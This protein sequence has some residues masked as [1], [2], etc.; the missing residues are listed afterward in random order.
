MRARLAL[1]TVALLVGGCSWPGGEPAVQRHCPNDDVPTL[2]SEARVPADA[3]QMGVRLTHL[4]SDCALDMASR[5]T[6]DATPAGIAD[7]V[8]RMGMDRGREHG[9]VGS[10]GYGI[11]DRIPTPTFGSLVRDLTIDSTTTA[12]T[13]SGV[14]QLF[15]T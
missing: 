11:Q 13:V 6:V 14:L 2:L 5:F 1:A 10:P 4:S 3:A 12:G 7:L 15:T 8:Q 9:T